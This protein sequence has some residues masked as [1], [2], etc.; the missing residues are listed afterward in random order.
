MEKPRDSSPAL[1]LLEQFSES[2]DAEAYFFA[3]NPQERSHWFIWFTLIYF[4][5]SLYQ[6]KELHHFNFLRLVDKAFWH[7][8][9]IETP[10][11]VNL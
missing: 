2:E 6:P 9:N 3:N 4:T 8:R 10:S 11:S 1:F 5:R 7:D